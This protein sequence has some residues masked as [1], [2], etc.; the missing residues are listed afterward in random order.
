VRSIQWLFCNVGSDG[1]MTDEPEGEG[2]EG[3]GL[4][5]VVTGAID[6]IW[7]LV[8]GI[9]APFRKNAIKAFTQLF[10]TGLEYP[11]TVIR[12]KIAEKQAESQARVKLIKTSATRIA[13]QMQ[14]PSAYAQAAATKF[15]HKIIRERVN[16]DQIVQI[17]AEELQSQPINE[18]ASEAA[19]I[20]DDW[21]NAF[22]NEAAQMSS[23]QMRRLFGKILAGEIRRPESYS[24]K[25]IKL[26]AQVDNRAAEF[27][28]TLCS[29][30]VSLRVHNIL[31]DTRVVSISGNA[32]QSSLFSYGLNFD[33][34]NILN[35]YGLIIA[36]Y[37]SYM[38]YRPAILLHPA[39][40]PVPLTYQNAPWVLVPMTPRDGSQA[41][42]L[43]GVG[44]SHVGRELLPIVEITPNE[45]YTAAL[46]K[47][48]DQQGLTLTRV[49]PSPAG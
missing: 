10:T 15:A 27:F 49:Q 34:L 23:E 32:A 17:A 3:S 5:S 9:P 26:V 19:S 22:E 28:Q 37:N 16:I 25:T 46:Q 48:F 35:E 41:L 44:F 2:S 21:L 33:A 1:H 18:A 31:W 12:G 42:N 13:K 39:A 43:F 45:A 29:L 30:S 36:D 8:T 40:N 11:K 14:I 24:I 6:A 38:D 4:P 47:F 7:Y 20:S